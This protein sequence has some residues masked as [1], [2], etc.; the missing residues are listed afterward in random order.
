M[1]LSWDDVAEGTIVRVRSVEDMSREFGRSKY[2]SIQVDVR[3]N[4]QM[5]GACGMTCRVVQRVRRS[6]F[7]ELYLEPEDASDH[8]WS[9]IPALPPGHSGT[10]RTVLQLIDGFKWS[11][12]LFEPVPAPEPPEI[13]ALFQ[14]LGPPPAGAL[15]THLR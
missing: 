1:T 11:T 3:W 6:D 8:R 10:A 2:G 7:I 13:S 4:W 14:L 15:T 12:Q 9:F 5:A